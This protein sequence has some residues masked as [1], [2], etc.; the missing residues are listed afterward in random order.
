MCELLDRYWIGGVKE[1]MLQGI[2]QGK[3]DAV[4]TL[5]VSMSLTLQQA[6]ENIGFT[7]EEYQLARQIRHTN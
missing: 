3:A 4:D 1:G 2:Q 6:C 7:I 5:M